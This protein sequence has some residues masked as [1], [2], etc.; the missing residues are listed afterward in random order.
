VVMY[1]E[2][3]LPARRHMKEFTWWDDWC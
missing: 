2:I 3:S 1:C